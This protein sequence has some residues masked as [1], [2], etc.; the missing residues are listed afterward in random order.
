MTQNKS[1]IEC[2]R[3]KINKSQT[4]KTILKLIP[5]VIFGIRPL[6]VYLFASVG[7][8][9]RLGLDLLDTQT[10]CIVQTNIYRKHSWRS[11]I[12]FGEENLKKVA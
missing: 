3:F 11:K 7:T 6:S 10:F 8:K 12:L 5:A 4:I 1:H 2:V 9:V